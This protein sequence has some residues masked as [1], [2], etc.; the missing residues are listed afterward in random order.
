[1]VANHLPKRLRLTFAGFIKRDQARRIEYLLVVKPRP[2]RSGTDPA[3]TIG[4]GESPERAMRSGV[5]RADALMSVTS[6]PFTHVQAR[7]VRVRTQRYAVDEEA[8]RRIAAAI[9]NGVA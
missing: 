7:P 6:R 2:I 1:M 9:P 4:R 3:L 5:R 8:F